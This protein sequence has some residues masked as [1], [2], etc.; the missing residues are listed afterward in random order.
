M[1]PAWYADA[2]RLRKRG[3]SLSQ[4]GLELDVSPQAVSLDLDPGKQA[5]R[6]KYVKAWKRRRYAESAFRKRQQK[7]DREAKKRARATSRRTGQ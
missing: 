3:M 2:K 7:L 4:I 6:R 1:A 5:R